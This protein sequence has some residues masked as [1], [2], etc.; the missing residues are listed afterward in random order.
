MS[1][2]CPK[3]AFICLDSSSVLGRVP[4]FSASS[5]KRSKLHGS[6]ILDDYNKLINIT[7]T[8]CHEAQDE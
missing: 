7:N 2:V 6:K 4:H 1:A 8:L 5:L 3:H